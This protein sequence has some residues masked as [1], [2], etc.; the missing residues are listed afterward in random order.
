[1]GHWTEADSK[2]A[3]WGMAL[4]LGVARTQNPASQYMN[5]V[6]DEGAV[7]K[8]KNSSGDN[9]NA[10]LDFHTD[11]ADVVGLLC[12]RTA[13]A[14][15]ERLV[16]S[17]MALAQALG[18]RRPDVLAVL[19]QPFFHHYPGSG[20]PLQPP[21]CACPIISSDPLHVTMRVNRKNI[22]AAQNDFPA[23]PRVTPQQW[24]AL[25][26]LEQLMADPQ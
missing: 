25:D 21:Y 19:Q 20:N 3:Y 5:D 16:A 26:L 14:G 2:L 13:Q 1:M 24:D 22:V 7:Y 23:L 18:R 11:S 10:G 12:R 17:T 4:H 8:G 6:R 9:T 15:V